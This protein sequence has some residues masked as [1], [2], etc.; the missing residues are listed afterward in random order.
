MSGMAVGAKRTN[1]SIGSGDATYGGAVG[2]PAAGTSDDAF[3]QGGFQVYSTSFTVTNNTGGPIQLETFYFD[4]DDNDGPRAIHLYYD[5]GDL[6]DADNTL[7]NSATGLS[8]GIGP[9]GTDYPDFSW[10]L[11]G[12]S[13]TILADGESATFRL[14]P[15]DQDPAFPNN[16]G[17]LDNVA[18]GGS[19]SA[20]TTPGTLI[21]GK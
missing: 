11:S 16:W 6:D 18:I 2:F 12:L 17:F 5:S 1:A 14:D 20:P 21:Y 7:I 9:V 3:T 10:S 4:Y 19:A 15:G 13:D 8:A